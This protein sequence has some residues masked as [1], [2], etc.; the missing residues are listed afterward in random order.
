MVR[1]DELGALEE[2]TSHLLIFLGNICL[3]QYSMSAEA[4]TN[5]ALVH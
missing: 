1:L 2:G 4:R 3:T 5:S